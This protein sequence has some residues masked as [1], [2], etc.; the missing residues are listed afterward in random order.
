[1]WILKTRRLRETNVSWKCAATRPYRAPIKLGIKTLSNLRRANRWQTA[2]NTGRT[3]A[4]APRT[5]VR[6]LKTTESRS[7]P[8]AS[9]LFASFSTR[10]IAE[11]TIA[12]RTDFRFPPLRVA[13]NGTD[14]TRN[15]TAHARTPFRFF[16]QPNTFVSYETHT[17]VGALSEPGGFYDVFTNIRSGY[18]ESGRYYFSLRTRRTH[19][20]LHF[21]SRC[22]CCR[23]CRRV[24]FRSF[25]SYLSRIRTATKIIW[26]LPR[27]FY[28]RATRR[29]TSATAYR[30]KMHDSCRIITTII[31]L[32]LQFFFSRSTTTVTK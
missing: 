12:A 27:V 10:R 22:F 9:S 8:T 2:A 14:F 31:A 13:V 7:S 6:D 15:E 30:W 26:F 5:I 16:F 32:E 20:A 3:H 11:L 17:V 18:F 21:I 25:G 28:E 4:Y 23:Y 24:F 1:M 19:V 29:F